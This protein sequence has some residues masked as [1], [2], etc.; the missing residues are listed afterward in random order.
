MPLKPITFSE[1]D[2]KKLFRTN[3]PM[4]RFWRGMRRVLKTTIWFIAIFGF[5]FAVMN[6]PAFWQ[7]ANFSSVVQP[8]IVIPP[9]V[10]TVNYDPEI[11]IAKI[12]VRAPVV[13]DASFDTIIE[14]LRTG[15]VR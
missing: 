7:R 15:V 8:P 5:F 11:I 9:P 12:G 1:K 2:L 3:T 10:P 13:Y 6:A 4:A 14:R